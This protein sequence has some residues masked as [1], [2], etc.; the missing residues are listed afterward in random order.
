[1]SGAVAVLAGLLPAYRVARAGLATAGRNTATADT[2]QHRL[3]AGLVVM[4]VWEGIVRNQVWL[5]DSIAVGIEDKAHL[6]GSLV[7]LVA[8]IAMLY[9]FNTSDI[10]A[11]TEM[12]ASLPS[13]S[14]GPR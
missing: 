10:P 14:D 7:M 1:M 5:G 13:R 12:A 2:A 6:A 11:L 8:V 9:Q 3:R 4:E